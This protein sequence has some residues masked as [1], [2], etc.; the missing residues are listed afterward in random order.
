M[1]E[2]SGDTTTIDGIVLELGCGACPEQY[3]VF[4]NDEYIG[5]MRLRHGMFTAMMGD[6]YELVYREYPKG[7]GIFETDERE[8]YLTEAVAAIKEYL[9]DL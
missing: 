8:K 1:Y 5:Y 6:D 4:H 3:D 7:D 9:Y 2:T